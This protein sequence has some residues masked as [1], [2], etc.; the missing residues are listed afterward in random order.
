MFD[1]SFDPRLLCELLN[2]TDLILQRREKKDNSIAFM[3]II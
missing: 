2:A 1:I 3:V